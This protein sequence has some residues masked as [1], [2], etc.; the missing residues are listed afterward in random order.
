MNVR[1]T[2]RVGDEPDDIVFAGSPRQAYVSVSQED[3]VEVLDPARPWDPPVAIA[4]PGDG[5]ARW[6]SRST[7][8]A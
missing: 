1:A 2:V 8:G 6:R 4:I 5:R 7:S 3:A